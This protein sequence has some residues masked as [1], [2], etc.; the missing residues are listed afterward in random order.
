MVGFPIWRIAAKSGP[1]LVAPVSFALIGSK[2]IRKWPTHLAIELNVTIHIKVTDEPIR[3]GRKRMTELL[4]RGHFL[5]VDMDRYH[6]GNFVIEP[7][8]DFPAVVPRCNSAP[9]IVI[10]R[11]EGP[12]S[13]MGPRVRHDEY[14]IGFHSDIGQHPDN[15]IPPRLDNI[16]PDSSHE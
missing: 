6:T 5:S 13:V 4:R 1:H 7:M 14:D 12:R 16:T 8:R 11:A 9:G 10:G 15:G 3:V 2:L